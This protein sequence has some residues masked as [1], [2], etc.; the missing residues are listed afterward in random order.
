MTLSTTNVKGDNDLIMPLYEMPCIG[1][2]TKSV[3][4]ELLN[5]KGQIAVHSLKDM[6]VVCDDRLTIGGIPKLMPRGDCLILK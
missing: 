6:P 5:N 3:E 4:I 1:V 2:F